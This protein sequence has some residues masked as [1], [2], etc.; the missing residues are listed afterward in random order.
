MQVER[1]SAKHVNQAAAWMRRR[2]Q[3]VIPPYVFDGGI[4]FVVDDIASCWL[5]PTVGGTVGLVEHLSANPIVDPDTRSSAIDAVIAACLSLAK[6]LGCRL[7]YSVTA[8]DAV[9]H[10]AIR[11]GYA[12]KG[13]G[14]TLLVAELGGG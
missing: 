9:V 3:K 1:A 12:V 14:M 4:G 6:S 13:R 10:R 2:G 5:F 7:V 11:H 8:V